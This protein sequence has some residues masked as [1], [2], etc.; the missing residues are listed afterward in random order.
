MRGYG[1]AYCHVLL[2]LSKGDVE[3]CGEWIECAAEGWWVLVNARLRKRAI[4]KY[5]CRL[6]HLVGCRKPLS[7]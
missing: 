6:L 2:E 7:L 1:Y 4:S 3:G 5:R